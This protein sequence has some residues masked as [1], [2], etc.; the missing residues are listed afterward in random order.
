MRMR[1]AI[2]AALLAAASAPALAQGNSL[3]EAVARDYRANLGALFDH[4]HRNPELSGRE[5]QDQRAHGPR[6]GALG[7]AVTTGVGALVVVA[8]LRKRRR[9]TVM[10]R[11]DMDGLP[12]EERSGVANRR[13]ARRPTLRH[14][15]PVMPPAA[16]TCTSPLW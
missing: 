9:A 8:V 16:P 4:F 13:G 6:T 2:M 5:V 15:A 3:R 1:Y 7:Y 10:L 14:R 11:A 12:L